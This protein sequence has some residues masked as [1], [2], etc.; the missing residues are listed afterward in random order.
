MLDKIHHIAIICSDYESEMS[1]YVKG[2]EFAVLSDTTRP[3]KNDRIV[4]LSMGES[5]DTQIELFIKEDAPKRV[6]YPEARGLR[7]LAFRVKDIEEL[8]SELKEKGIQAEEIR[9]DSFTG[10]RMTFIH[11]PD[12]LPIE[13]HE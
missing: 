8:V 9:R 5:T 7:H 11:D 12:G 2:L 4:M 13:L 3:E 6:N 10:E 1:F